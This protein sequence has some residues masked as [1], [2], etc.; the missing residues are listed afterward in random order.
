M[1][2]VEMLR[3]LSR[4]PASIVVSCEGRWFTAADFAPITW[5]GQHACSHRSIPLTKAEQNG[6]WTVLNYEKG[7]D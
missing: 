6:E 4:D 1:A 7:A 2:I 5:I 3:A